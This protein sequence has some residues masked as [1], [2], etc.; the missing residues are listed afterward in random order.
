MSA[1]LPIVA[2]RS[3]FWDGRYYGGHTDKAVE[4][5]RTRWYFAEGSQG[6]FDTYVLLANPNGATASVT[7]SFLLESGAPVAKVYGVGPTSRLTIHAGSIPELRG[8]S[9]GIVVESNAPIVAE[10][11][12][13]F[14]TPLFNGGHE[15]AGVGAPSLTW[16]HAEGATGEFFD[17]YVLVSNPNETV[18]NVAFTF[19][20][21]DGT[22][23]TKF[24]IIGANARLTVNV[25]SED[26]RLANAAVS[27]VVTG[28]VP[29]ISERA[30]YWSGA[31]TG[32]YEAH[33][34]F[35]VT[36]TAFDWALAEGRTG[37]EQGFETY[38]LLANPGSASADIT[39]TFLKPDGTT[40]VKT[41]AVPA[42]SRFNIHVNSMV[43]ELVNQHFGTVIASSGPIA[44]ERAMY[45]N[46]GGVT[47][48]AGTNAT[49]TKLQ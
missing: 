12:M 27:A 6:F 31:F 46:A 24:K 26:P 4:A 10:R 42:T 2:E 1:G 32:W 30:M 47:W 11:A 44:V 48:A 37:G 29:V 36:A 18:A 23:I 5:P 22:A 45:A 21:Q 43:P 39:A 25:E 20:L 34:S 16:F 14:G 40:I 3:M 19:L 28:D 35:G 49:A 9:F 13:Y 38:I 33:N 7:I 17:T 8:K 15:S 41:Y